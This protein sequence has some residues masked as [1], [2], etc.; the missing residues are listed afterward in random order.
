[1]S[2]PDYPPQAPNP[3]APPGHPQHRPQGYAP[4]GYAPQGYVPQGYAPQQHFAPQPYGHGFAVRNKN[5]G[6]VIGASVLWI[7]YGSLALLGNLVALGGSGGRA[8][9]PT[10]IGLSLGVAFLVTGIQ[11]LMGKARGLLAMGITSI[12]FGG[13]TSIAFL[14]LG[15]LVR[16]FRAPGWLLGVGFVVGGMLITAGVLACIGNRAYKDWRATKF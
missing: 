12:V 3:Y 2:T 10:L 6:S 15:S 7:I 13:L 14:L 11:A 5:P 8:G 1:M 4:Q 9:M 16:G